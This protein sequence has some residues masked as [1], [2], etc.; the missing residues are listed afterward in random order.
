MKLIKLYLPITKT[1]IEVIT[2][3]PLSPQRVAILLL[4]TPRPPAKPVANILL[5]PF[6]SV[7]PEN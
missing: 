2:T 4:A 5:K 3:F 6:P 7:A 1:N